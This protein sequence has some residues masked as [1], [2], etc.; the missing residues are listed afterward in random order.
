MDMQGYFTTKGLALSAKLL[1]GTVLTI[2]R[3]VAGNGQTQTTAATL[4]GPRQTLAV[5]SPTRSGNTAI[6]PVTLVAAGASANYTLTE[7]GVYAKDPDEGEILY[8][9]YKLSQPVNVVAGS[10]MVLRFY[11]E[12]TVSQNL[13][14]VVE[15]SPAGLITEEIFH[16]VRDKVMTESCPSRTVSVDAGDLQT[17]LNR[18]PKLV[19]ENLT[20]QVS[21][22][23]SD[24]ITLKS[25]YGSG[26]I[27]IK[28]DASAGCTFKRCIHVNDC[29]C[30]IWLDG[31]TFD[32][33]EQL[34]K[35]AMVLVWFSSNVHIMK[36]S[37]SG[38]GAGIAISVSGVSH[39][40][41]IECAI[42]NFSVALDGHNNAM[43]FVMNCSDVSGNTTGVQAG[44]GTITLLGGTPNLLGGAANY[45]YSGALIV[46]TGNV[47]L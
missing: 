1:T 19:T 25:F 17:F 5:N 7:L 39:A 15:C 12:E 27:T 21:G 41:V 35:T 24:F 2:S 34:E 40:R 26:S 10:S 45:K 11:L 43:I 13:D 14:A 8:K 20:I 36:C 23:T 44:Y 3:V 4:S 22:I 16:P 31:L 42:Q 6:I 47:L 33:A 18:L 46:S 37:F 28:A 38:A 30:N 29:C 9:I 32:D